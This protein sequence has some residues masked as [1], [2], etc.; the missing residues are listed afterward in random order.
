MPFPDL[1]DVGILAGFER[2]GC[3]YHGLATGGIIAGNEKLLAEI[4]WPH[5]W[6]IQILVFA[7]IV[8]Y[9]TIHELVRYIGRDRAVKIFFGPLPRGLAD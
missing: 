7:L 2:W 1:N 5:F 3:P 9:S 8:A 6:A 4:V